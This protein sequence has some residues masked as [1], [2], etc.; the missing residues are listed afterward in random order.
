MKSVGEYNNLNKHTLGL[1]VQTT[2]FTTLGVFLL[3]FFV[4]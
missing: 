2:K 4:L 3:I 1:G